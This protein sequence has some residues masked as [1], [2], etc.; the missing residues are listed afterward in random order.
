MDTIVKTSAAT[1]ADTTAT[2]VAEGF[3]NRFDAVDA[4]IADQIREG[5]LA[6]GPVEPSDAEV[7]RAFLMAYPT[8][9]V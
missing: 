7:R 8:L 6:T 9:R 1:P 2:L 4:I 3:M 5:F